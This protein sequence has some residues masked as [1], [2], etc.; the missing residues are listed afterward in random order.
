MI[1]TVKFWAVVNKGHFQSYKKQKF[2][3]VNLQSHKLL[4]YIID[5]VHPI[6]DVF[7]SVFFCGK[8]SLRR[9]DQFE[10]FRICGCGCFPLSSV[11][12]LNLSKTRH[13]Q[14]EINMLLQSAH[15]L[16]HGF[17]FILL[18]SSII[19]TNIHACNQTECRT[20]TPFSP[21]TSSHPINWTSLSSF[22]LVGIPYSHQGRALNGRDAQGDGSKGGIIAKP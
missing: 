17:L 7:A 15:P 16:S 12:N 14:E 18:F 20:P 5:F 8:I 6:N 4:Q 11:Y 2:P 19:S 22:H 9:I 13:I 10:E 21:N 3:C 1:V